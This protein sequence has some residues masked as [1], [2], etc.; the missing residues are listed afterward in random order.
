MIFHQKIKA[1]KTLFLGGLDF[2]KMHQKRFF[3][4]RFALKF[5]KYNDFVVCELITN[6]TGAWVG[7]SGHYQGS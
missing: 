2:Q 3:T 1:H 6:I 4:R 7:G 5:K